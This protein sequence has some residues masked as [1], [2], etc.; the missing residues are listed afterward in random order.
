MPQVCTCLFDTRRRCGH[1]LPNFGLEKA[2]YEGVGFREGE[3]KPTQGSSAAW[4]KFLA[5]HFSFCVSLRHNSSEPPRTSRDASFSLHAKFHMPENCHRTL[6]GRSVWA[7]GL[8]QLLLLALT[9]FGEFVG[10]LELTVSPREGVTRL[11]EAW[12]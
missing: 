9:A 10:N 11:T 3:R 12:G 6:A 4:Y 2:G 5:N 1:F 7:S 8:W